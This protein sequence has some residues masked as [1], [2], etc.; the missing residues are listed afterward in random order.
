M[1]N[2]HRWQGLHDG[3][4]LLHDAIILCFQE[5]L[6]PA[7][8][9]FSYKALKFLSCPIFRHKVPHQSVTISTNFVYHRKQRS[10]N[11]K[12]RNTLQPK[13][14]LSQLYI[15]NQESNSTHKRKERER[16]GNLSRIA[17]ALA[18]CFKSRDCRSSHEL[19]WS[20]AR[21]Y[22]CSNFFTKRSIS[23]ASKNSGISN[24]P[25]QR[26]PRLQKHKTLN[27]TSQ[28]QINANSALSNKNTRRKNN[29]VHILGKAPTDSISNAEI[30]HSA[31]TLVKLATTQTH[32][33]AEFSQERGTSRTQALP[34]LRKKTF[35]YPPLD[36]Y[37][38]HYCTP[39][40][41]ITAPPH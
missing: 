19:W 37:T 27:Y 34:E 10:I 14:C 22:L 16:T 25:L 1:L 28:R 17:P 5:H 29:S 18:N 20:K 4:H 6:K 7:P 32:T 23:C 38:R 2:L 31:I 11:F 26:L 21:R 40:N 8:K 39:I 41:S 12:K 30:S 24:H 9:S 36:G 35:Q 33:E 13:N 15:F 3:R